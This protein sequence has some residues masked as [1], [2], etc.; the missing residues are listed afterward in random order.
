MLSRVCERVC[1]CMCMRVHFNLSL[2]SDLSQMGQSLGV[3]LERQGG[4]C[5][6]ANLTAVRTHSP[7]SC[8][9]PS[10]GRKSQVLLF[11]VS[12]QQEMAT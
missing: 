5:G 6:S 1:A 11:P 12:L 7:A 3:S 2:L 9:T 4:H 10:G 8:L